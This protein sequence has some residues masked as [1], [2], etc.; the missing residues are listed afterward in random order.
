MLVIIKPDSAAHFPI[1]VIPAQPSPMSFPEA[2]PI[3]SLPKYSRLDPFGLPPYSKKPEAPK[4]DYFSFVQKSFKNFE[5][6]QKQAETQRELGAQLLRE[7]AGP[8]RSASP[9]TV[10]DVHAFF[11]KQ[12]E[13]KLPQAE[14]MLKTLEK[15]TPEDV[16]EKLDTKMK[17]V[18]GP[19]GMRLVQGFLAGRPD[20]L[21]A[22]STQH[23]A[24][25]LP[26]SKAIGA[27]YGKD[28]QKRLDMLIKN[29]PLAVM[30][31]SQRLATQ[32]GDILKSA[33][34]K[35]REHMGKTYENL[36]AQKEHPDFETLPTERKAFIDVNLRTMEE[37]ARLMAPVRELL[38]KHFLPLHRL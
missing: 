22:L 35:L 2:A 14:K 19:K 27:E 38:T 7:V 25:L 1:Q 24:K 11:D 36:L 6:A 31:G 10:A 3:E 26:I 28:V 34:E 30:I 12:A 21:L 16:V 18:L 5:A 32:G 15:S 13:S 23:Q 37:F 4:S 20:E 9:E 29:L 33:E 8:D 17:E